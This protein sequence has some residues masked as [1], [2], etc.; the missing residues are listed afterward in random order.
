MGVEALA[1]KALR[2]QIKHLD[3]MRIEDLLTKGVADVNYMGGWIELKAADRWPMRGGPLRLDHYTPAQKA[4]GMKRWSK[5]RRCFVLLRVRS[6]WLL[7]D[8][9]TAAHYLGKCNRQELI[10]VAL[11]HHFGL[12]A[13]LGP[14]LEPWLTGKGM[15]PAQ[16]QHWTRVRSMKKA[17]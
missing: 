6:D 10:D 13:E 8:A 14:A 4:W 2:P 15:T 16:K 17:D 1:W 3:P 11:V 12:I 7:F 5:G 9:F